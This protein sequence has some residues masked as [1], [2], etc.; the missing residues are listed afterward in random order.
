MKWMIMAAILLWTSPAFSECRIVEYPDHNEA[1][2]S[3][4]PPPAKA[5]AQQEAEE[6]AQKINEAKRMFKECQ[7]EISRLLKA[8]ATAIYHFP[9]PE[10][11]TVRTLNSYTMYVAVDAQN[12]YGALIRDSFYCNFDSNNKVIYAGKDNGLR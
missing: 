9:D 6:K 8:P 5:I 11:P 4:V 3:D 1:V 7:I 12:G 2:C 10:K